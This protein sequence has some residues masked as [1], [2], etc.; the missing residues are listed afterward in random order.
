MYANIIPDTRMLFSLMYNMR[1]VTL[2]SFYRKEEREGCREKEK[3]V[4]EVRS[5]NP[6]SLTLSLSEL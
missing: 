3:K 2:F 5:S 6:G 1:S 4:K